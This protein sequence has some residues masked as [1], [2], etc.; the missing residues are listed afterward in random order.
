MPDIDYA[1]RIKQLCVTHVGWKL[2]IDYMPNTP[3]TTLTSQVTSMNAY[4][5]TH[6]YHYVTYTT[7]QDIPEDSVTTMAEHSSY[8]SSYF[9]HAGQAKWEYVIYVESLDPLAAGWH[10]APH[11]YGVR[12]WDHGIA[13]ND[14]YWYMDYVIWHEYGHHIFISIPIIGPEVYC[15][16]GGCVMNDTGGDG[17]YCFYHFWQRKT[18]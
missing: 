8:Y 18:F 7:S 11:F 9:D 5:K 16:N 2:E 6:S 3:I 4:Y 14:D 1:K 10:L 17:W 12:L 13:I 15:S